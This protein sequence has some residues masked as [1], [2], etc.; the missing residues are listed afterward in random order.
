MLYEYSLI[1]IS[2]TSSGYF[3]TPDPELFNCSSLLQKI[4]V[5][6][7]MAVILVLAVLWLASPIDLIPDALPFGGVDDVVVA[8]LSST[9]VKKTWS[10]SQA[11]DRQ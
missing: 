4:A 2:A 1:T 7:R 6:P 3:A 9:I 5:L 10:S 11:G 8:I